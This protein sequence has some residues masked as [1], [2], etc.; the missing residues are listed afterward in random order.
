M[1]TELECYHALA[2]PRSTPSSPS[3]PPSPFLTCCAILTNYMGCGTWRFN[4]T[5]TRAF[6]IKL[7]I[8]IKSHNLCLGKFYIIRSQEKNSTGVRTSDHRISSQA[9]CHLSYPG[10]HASSC[11]NLSLETDA[12]STRR[13]GHDTTCHYIDH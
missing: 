10:S 13:C 5:F 8:E 12:T 1:W 7:L 2:S 9:L 11:S 6:Q 3:A 4:A